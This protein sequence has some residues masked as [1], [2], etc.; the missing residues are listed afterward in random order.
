MAEDVR[1][2]FERYRRR[3]LRVRAADAFLVRGWEVRHITDRGCT[4]HRLT[5]FARV[6]GTRIVYAR[7]AALSEAAESP[8]F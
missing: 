5:P 2:A 4:P 7:P 8:P 6:Q 3:D 1:R